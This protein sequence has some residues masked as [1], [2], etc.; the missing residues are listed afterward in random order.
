MRVTDQSSGATASG[1]R[2]TFG[3]GSKDVRVD[4]RLSGHPAM[5]RRAGVL[6]KTEA[7]F[8]VTCLQALGAG[9]LDVHLPGGQL[10]ARL[11]YGSSFRCVNRE[12]LVVLRVVDGPTCDLRVETDSEVKISL[13][14][15]GTSTAQPWSRS[16]ILH[17]NRQQEWH[18]VIAIAAAK[19]FYGTSSADGPEPTWTGSI[20]PKD[21]LVRACGKWFGG[22]PSEHWVTIRLDR[23][24]TALGFPIDGTDK[25]ARIVPAVLA[26]EL[27]DRATLRLVYERL[28]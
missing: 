6:E 13:A 14:P 3:R 5:S 22:K 16:S 12:V 7:G 2:V 27:I 15:A 8:T 11:A 26:G 17:P 19:A 4:L 24:L 20:P 25:L 18:T 1:E 10:V 21:W 23:A 9:Y 28:S